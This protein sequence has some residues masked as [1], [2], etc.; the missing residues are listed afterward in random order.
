[1][2]NRAY[3][4]SI[5]VKGKDTTKGIP[6]LSPTI[7]KLIAVAIVAAIAMLVVGSL[8]NSKNTELLTT[9]EKIYSTYNELSSTSGPLQQYKRNLKS[10]TVRAITTQ[11]QTSITNTTAQLK[12]AVGQVGVDTSSISSEATSAVSADIAALS[13]SCESGFYAGTLDKSYATAVYLQISKMIALQTEARQKTDDA[14]FASIMESSLSDLQNIQQQYKDY[15]DS[16][17]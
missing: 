10:S 2:D 11:F 4:D 9:Y 14:N 7:I 12:N 3:L 6:I 17:N 8:L 13:N 15:I 1:M 16:A 5:A